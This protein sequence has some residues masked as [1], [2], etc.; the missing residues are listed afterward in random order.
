MIFCQLLTKFCTIFFLIYKMK[1]TGPR[2]IYIYISLHYYIWF[3]S[4]SQLKLAI[5]LSFWSRGY[6]ICKK[7]RILLV[8]WKI[9]KS[10]PNYLLKT[11]SLGSPKLSPCD[12]PKCFKCFKSKLLIGKLSN[13]KVSNIAWVLAICI[14]LQVF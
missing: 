11:K 1:P 9:H 10:F 14:K 7:F 2:I 4:Y 6:P 13:K 12:F 5:I 8:F 3:K